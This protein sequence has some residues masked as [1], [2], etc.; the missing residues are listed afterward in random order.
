MRKKLKLRAITLGAILGLQTSPSSPAV[1]GDTPLTLF[2]NSFAGRSYH[3][4]SLKL[5]P[6]LLSADTT[7]IDPEIGYRFAE[8]G[9]FEIYLKPDVFGRAALHCSQ[10]KIRMPWTSPTAEDSAR[11]IEHKKALFERIERMRKDKS[12]SLELVLQ[13]D[14]YLSFQSAD[15]Y[16]LTQCIAFFRTA[17]GAY[18]D[19]RN[20]IADPPN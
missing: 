20:P 3:H 18:V 14:P 19:H 11:K 1:A 2:E 9:L 15:N 8:G 16:K 13:L 12:G 10:V 6:E 4:A 5:S 7:K 17:F